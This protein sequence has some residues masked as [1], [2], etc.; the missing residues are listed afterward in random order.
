[1]RLDSFVLDHIAVVNIASTGL[2]ADTMLLNFIASLLVP[3]TQ[4]SSGVA[5]TDAKDSAAPG[6]HPA[7]I[8][9]SSS[10]SLCS[11]VHGCKKD[12][13]PGRLKVNLD[14]MLAAT[15]KSTNMPMRGVPS[16]A[17]LH[18]ARQSGGGPAVCD[19]IGCT[20]L[21]EAG[22]PKS[23]NANRMMTMRSLTI[24]KVILWQ[25]SI[26]SEA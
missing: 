19:V 6:Y 16:T 3:A 2:N 12:A 8:S 4:M 13:E 1:M 14:E 21:G 20:T 10:T 24:S 17:M 23:P 5:W 22:K 25:A 11:N 9:R 18:S 7:R 15:S 26:T